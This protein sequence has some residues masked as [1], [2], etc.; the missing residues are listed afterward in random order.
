MA[1]PAHEDPEARPRLLDAVEGDGHGHGVVRPALVA[2]GAE[3][4][5]ER[6][7]RADGPDLL[8]D[9]LHARH[10]GRR[11]GADGRLHGGA[12]GVSRLLRGVVERGGP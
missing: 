3:L 7:V 5:L 12:S 11:A 1:G 2:D 10:V 9:L 4:L 8:D 6:K